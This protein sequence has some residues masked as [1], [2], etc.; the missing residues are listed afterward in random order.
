[1]VANT[2]AIFIK[3]LAIFIRRINIIHILDSE[4]YLIRLDEKLRATT[5]TKGMIAQIL[6]FGVF[7]QSALIE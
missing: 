4:N 6:F 2:M 7:Q 3:Y 5:P 1:M